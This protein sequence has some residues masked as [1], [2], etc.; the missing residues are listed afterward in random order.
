MQSLWALATA[1]L[2]LVILA[3]VEAVLTFDVA[4]NTQSNHIF[5]GIRGLV[6][7]HYAPVAVLVFFGAIAGPALHLGAIWYVASACCLNQRWPGVHRVARLI[8]KLAPWNLM[9]VYAVAL[10]VAVVR[11][12]LLGKV[13]WQQ[14]AFWIVVLSLCSLVIAQYYDRVDAAK[15]LAALK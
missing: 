2:I 13:D 4:G 1:G 7:Q 12:D 5:T 14:G 11:L 3:N 9:P 8:E 10:L 15:R 6:N